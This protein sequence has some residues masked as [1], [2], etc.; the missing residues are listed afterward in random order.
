[1]NR[2]LNEATVKKFHYETL[3]KLKEH[4]QVFIDAYNVGKR[5]NALK[6]LTVFDYIN[7]CWKKTLLCSNPIFN[8]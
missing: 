2:P 4:V 5:L 7:K 3:G 1:M 8:T 6:G